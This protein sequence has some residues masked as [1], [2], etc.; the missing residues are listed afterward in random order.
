[1]RLTAIVTL[2]C[3][4]AALVVWAAQPPIGA[5]PDDRSPRMKRQQV[6]DLLKA[7]HAKSLEDAAKLV[8]L[9]EELK[10]EI[11]KNDRHVLALSALRKTEEIEKIA[12]RI[13]GRMKRF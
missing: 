13:R 11:E 8:K 7:D 3:A 2:L 9:A 5:E 12:R 4:L 6:E 1:M 10:S